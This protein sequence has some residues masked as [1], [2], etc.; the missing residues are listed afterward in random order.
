MATTEIYSGDT[1]AVQFTITDL[2]GDSVNL[3][4]ATF[5]YVI[6]NMDGTVLVTKT[7]G[8]V[9]GAGSNVV[10]FALTE[11]DTSSLAGLY[12]HELE[13]TDSGS[14]VSTAY[15]G[16]LNVLTDYT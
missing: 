9:S 5:S 12:R 8:T 13:I 11:S 4:G 14:N 16:T 6:V 10:T 2:D 7:A 15:Q 3:T 1:K